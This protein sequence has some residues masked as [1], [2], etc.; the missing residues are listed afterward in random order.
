VYVVFYAGD[1]NLDGSLDYTEFLDFYD[2]LNQYDTTTLVTVYVRPKM[3]TRERFG[4]VIE[5]VYY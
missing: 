1:T 3:L 5:E 2:V 4:I